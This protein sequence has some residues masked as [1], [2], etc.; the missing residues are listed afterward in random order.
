M[1]TPARSTTGP[2]DGRPTVAAMRV[3]VQQLLGPEAELPTVAQLETLTLRLRG[4]A[5]QLIPAVES[6]AGRLPEDD[7]P[8]ACAL[9]CV[10]EARMRL[11]AEPRSG[12]PAGISFA[13]SLARCVNALCDHVENL[14]GGHS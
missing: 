4:Y 13:Q 3:S 8:R 12:L 11:N 5:M 10:G 2:Q 1:T 9:A 14:V 6:S 7:V